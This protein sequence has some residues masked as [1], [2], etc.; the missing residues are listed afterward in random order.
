MGIYPTALPPFLPAGVAG[1][2]VKWLEGLLK[3]AGEGVMNREDGN[4]TRDGHLGYA[5]TAPYDAID[6]GVAA[7]DTY[8]RLLEQLKK[9]FIP[10]AQGE[11]DMVG[12]R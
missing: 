11:P 7:V 6:V 3:H 10:L 12:S 9:R 2:L 8:E 5:P 4:A 1:E